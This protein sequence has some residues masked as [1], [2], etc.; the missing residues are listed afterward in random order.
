MAAL[1]DIF[2]DL[3]TKRVDAPPE[4]W[5][6]CQQIAEAFGLSPRAMRERLTSRTDIYE[7]QQITLC[8]HLTRVWRK[9]AE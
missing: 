6:T 7:V 4:G 1:R 3:V 8:G 9:K 2:A 5:Y